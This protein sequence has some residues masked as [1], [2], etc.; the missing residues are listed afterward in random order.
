MIF[1]REGAVQEMSEKNRY[2]IR[3][4]ITNTECSA[5]VFSGNQ[6]K[7]FSS[8]DEDHAGQGTEVTII[9]RT[10]PSILD[11]ICLTKYA[12]SPVLKES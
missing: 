8:N 7:Q 1:V 10:R 11:Y 9:K 12:E 2:P 3:G 6:Y 5:P 4:L